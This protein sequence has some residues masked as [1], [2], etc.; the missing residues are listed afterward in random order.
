MSEPQ[1]PAN[2]LNAVRPEWGTQAQDHLGYE[3]E[4]ERKAKRG[5]EDWELVEKMPESQK[6]VP[7]WFFAVVA[8][9]LLVAIGLAFPFWGTRPG[10]PAR[11]WVDWGFAEALVYTAVAGFFVYKMVHMYTGPVSD[12]K[13]EET[14]S[15]KPEPNSQNGPA[16]TH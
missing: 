3:S 6:P 7:Y 5:L 4:E 12:P 14:R 10:G 11:S 2:K 15:D 8:V 1:R 16:A 9:V 13:D